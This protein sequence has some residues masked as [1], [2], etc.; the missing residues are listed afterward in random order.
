M[1]FSEPESSFRNGSWSTVTRLW[2]SVSVPEA[3]TAVL[4]R[5]HTV[6]HGAAPR[7]T[8]PDHPARRHDSGGGGCQ[9]W[10][11]HGDEPAGEGNPA[12]EA[13]GRQ[14]P[15]R[16]GD[17]APTPKT[18]PPH[19]GHLSVRPA[20]RLSAWFGFAFPASVFVSAPVFFHR[21]PLIS[22]EASG[23]QR[24]R[25]LPKLAA[26]GAGTF[27]RSILPPDWTPSS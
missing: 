7:R 1:F 17:S 4:P 5:S 6:T 19:A 8:F 15:P 9:G 16:D 24:Q 14:Q 26:V 2:P 23:A 12:P 22:S 10:A 3:V 27:F 21:F 20:R 25:P 13:S 11:V 18:P